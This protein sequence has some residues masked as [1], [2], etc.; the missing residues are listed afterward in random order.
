MS[1]IRPERPL[2]RGG[3]ALLFAAAILVSPLSPI[4]ASLAL[5]VMTLRKKKKLRKAPP[6]PERY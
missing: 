2:I 6:R 4:A 3:I 5:P 1:C